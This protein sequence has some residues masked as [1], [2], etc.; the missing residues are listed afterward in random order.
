MCFLSVQPRTTFEVEQGTPILL[1]VSLDT[2]LRADTLVLSLWIQLFVLR[3]RR[4]RLHWKHLARGVHQGS[5]FRDVLEEID[6]EIVEPR[7]SRHL[8]HCTDA[9]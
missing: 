5:P 3:A 4:W 7:E 9:H 2:W 1:A 6:R 8:F